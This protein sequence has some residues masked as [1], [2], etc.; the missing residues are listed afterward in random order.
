[1][2][3]P[4]SLLHHV[5]AGIATVF[6]LTNPVLAEKADPALF[7]IL[8]QSGG[9][10]WIEAEAQILSAWENTGSEAL[11]M[12]QIRGEAALDDGDY[13]SAIGHFTALIDYAPDHATGFQLRA[14]AY[15]LNGNYGPAAADIAQA[16]KLEP[17]QYLALTLLSTMLEE[18]GN[19]EGAAEA[20][21]YSLEINPHQQDAIDAAAR[22][23][24]LKTGTDI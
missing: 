6:C 8:A 1:M 19:K 9:D 23:E 4:N 7:K 13:I 21:R 16:L 17:K 24:E 18:L 15:R 2:M 20:L 3:T 14:T 11:N 22:L 12:I 10:A 5:T